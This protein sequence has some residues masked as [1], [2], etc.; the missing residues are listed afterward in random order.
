LRAGRENATDTYLDISATDGDDVYNDTFI[1]TTVEAGTNKSARLQLI[2]K[3]GKFTISDESNDDGSKLPRGKVFFGLAR[4]HIRP[5]CA[6]LGADWH[7][8]DGAVQVV[9]RTD[10]KKGDEIVLSYDTGL[11]GFPVQTFEGV[12]MTALLNF[13]IVPGVKVAIDNSNVQQFQADLGQN[14]AASNL[15]IPQI[16]IDGAYKVLYV[17]HSGDTRGQKWYSDIIG[18]SGDEITNKA[19]SKYAINLPAIY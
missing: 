13:N 10:Y 17:S 1:N 14:S 2:A 16:S 6:N 4:D 15:L 3:A 7:I 18:I 8:K 9:S 12:T 19:Q 11:I 5:L